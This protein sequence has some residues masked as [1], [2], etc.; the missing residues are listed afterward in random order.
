M[1]VRSPTTA[2]L[3]VIAM[4]SM[5]LY[6]FDFLPSTAARWECVDCL[7]DF[8]PVLFGFAALAVG[9]RCAGLDSV[10]VCYR[11]IHFLLL[12]FE[13]C[14]DLFENQIAAVYCS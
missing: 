2:R 13:F 8:V 6:Q 7:E 14:C 1:I 9:V 10:D 5:L 12:C 4:I 11:N 3:Q